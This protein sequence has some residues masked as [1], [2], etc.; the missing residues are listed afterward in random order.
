[1]CP[2]GNHQRH[3]GEIGVGVGEEV[4]VKMRFDVMDPDKGNFQC[5]RQPLRRRDPDQK[6]TEQTGPVCHRDGVKVAKADSRL[7]PVPAES[8]D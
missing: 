4:G 7:R 3:G 8:P 6:R 1:M 5:H 2:A